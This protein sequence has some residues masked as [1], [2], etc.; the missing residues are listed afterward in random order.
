[1]SESHHPHVHAHHDQGQDAAAANDGPVTD[2]V[3]GMKVDPKTTSHRA[4]R[5][6]RQFFFC[7]AGCK[8][9]FEADPDRYLASGAKPPATQASAGTIYTCPMHP[10]I[11]QVGPGA[12]PI[13]GMALEPATITADEGPSPELKDMTLRFWL[14]LALAVPVFA[15]E[16]GGHLTGLMMLLSRQTSN[17]IQLALGTPVV[18]WAGWPFFVRGWA[19]LRSR[20]LNMFTLIAMGTGVAYVY[21]LVGTVAPDVRSRARSSSTC[22]SRTRTVITAAASK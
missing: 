19:S 3:C 21:S 2:P 18:L 6:G 1:M 15:L 20:N 7:S 22:P 4:E 13:C 11:R 17:W 9:K 16:M 10:Q 8:T 5:Q 14:G 12:C